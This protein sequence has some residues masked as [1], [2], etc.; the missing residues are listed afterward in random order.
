MRTPVLAFTPPDV[1]FT[2]C[3]DTQNVSFV[4]TN[5]GDGIAYN[6][7]TIV[8]FS[9]F[10]VSNVSAGATYKS[11]AGRFE[12]TNPLAAT[13]ATG[14]SYTLSFDLTYDTWCGGSFPAG[15]LLW[16]KLYEDECGQAFYL[17]V[18][19]SAINAPTSSSSLAVAKT[20][21]PSQIEIGGS[22]TYDVTSTYTGQLN[23]DSPSTPTGLITVVDILPAGLVITAN[24][25]GGDW[26]AGARTLTWTYMPST[27]P[28]T[29][30]F[31]YTV[32][33]PDISQ[34]DT[35]CGTSF[36]NSVVASG[37]DCCGCAIS[38][39]SSQTTVI[40]CAVGVTSDKTSNSP[41]E[42]CYNITYTNTYIFD[43][44]SA[45]LLSDLIFTEHAELKQEYGGNLSVFLNGVDI[46]GPVPIIGTN[47]FSGGS[48]IVPS[49]LIFN[50]QVGLNQK[51]NG[52][53][54]VTQDS[55]DNVNKSI[56]LTPTPTVFVTD[57]T[58]TLA[59]NGLI[60]NF[61]EDTPLAGS[62]L[63]ISYDLT[64]TESTLTACS[65]NTFYSWSSLEMSGGIIIK[66]ATQVSLGSPAMSVSISGLGQIYNTC[67]TKT[68]TLTVTQTSNYNPKDVQVVLSGLNYF[69]VAPG[70]V[71]C[72]GSV[73][74]VACTP[75]IDGSGDYVWTFDDGFASNGA[76]AIFTIK[77]QK[78]CTGGGALNATAY[79]DDHCIDDTN[80]DKLCSV[81]ASETPALLLLADLLIEK[82]PE[83]YYATTN[84]VQWEI[85]L[86]NRGTGTA[87]NVWVDDVL[88]SGLQY[89]HGVNPIVVDNMTGVTISDALDHD[90][91]AINGA[92]VAIME[93]VA[94]ERRRI[95]FI[96]EQ[97]NCTGLTNDVIANWGC[98]NADCQS[99]VTDNSIVQIP[100]PNLINTTTITPVNGLN[101]CENPRGFISVKNAGQIYTYNL[102]VTET[103][104]VGLS[105][106]GG[107]TKWRLNGGGWN[108]P[109]IIWDPS[110][111]TSPLVWTSAEIPELASL[112]PGDII[113][114]EF[115][116]ASDGHFAGGNIT[117]VTQYENPCATVFNTFNST[118]TIT[119]TEPNVDIS[120]E[121]DPD[122]P[123]GCNQ[124]IF[125][126]ITV[127][128]NGEYP[129]EI[130]WVESTLDAAF[131]YTST[132]VTS[133]GAYIADTGD[134]PGGGQ[135]VQ[136]EIT[137]LPAGQSV[138]LR[139]QAQTDQSSDPCSDNT[140][141]TVLAWWG[142]GNP[143]GSS[144][145]KPGVDAPDNALCLS[146][147]SV[148]T[149]RTETRQ[150]I[151]AYLS[152]AMSPSSINSCST[153]SEITVTIENSGPTDSFDN[154]LVL[155]LPEGLTYNAGSSMNSLHIDEAKAIASLGGIGDPSSVAG[156]GGTTILTW[157]N[158]GD[159]ASDLVDVIQAYGGNDTQVLRFTVQSSCY[160]TSN[161]AFNL[162]Y[163]DCCG[164]T[165][166]STT[167]SDQLTSLN[168][169]LSVV[170]TADI[171]NGVCGSDV[172]YTI[173][174]TNNGT[175]NA[176]VVRIVD[177]MGDW[178]SWNG[179]FTEDA[180]GTVTPAR[181]GANPQTWGWEFNNLAPAA[182]ATFTFHATLNSDGD[183]CAGTLRE[184]NVTAAWACGVGGEHTDN[185][186][187]TIGYNCNQTTTIASD[188]PKRLTMPNLIITD[189]APV[190][191]CTT[192]GNFSRTIQVT[193]QN[194][195]D[196]PTN[197]SIFTVQVQDG[198]GWTGT[199]THN[200]V[201][202]SGGSA[203]VTINT[204]TWNPICQTS[205]AGYNF[206]GTVDLNDNVCECLETIGDNTFTDPGNPYA[207]PIPDVTV[208][209]ID[210]ANVSCSSD[211][212]SDNVRV[213]VTNNGCVAANNFQLALTTDGCL[214]FASQTVSV[215]ATSSSWFTFNI[216]GNWADCT[217]DACD[218]IATV[219][220]PTTLCECDGTNNSRT[221]TY[222]ST[223]PDL[224]VTNIDYSNVSC[225]ADAV[226]GFVRVTVQNQGFG[227]ATNFDVKLTT[228]GCLTFNTNQTIAGPIAYGQTTSVDFP[229]AGTWDNPAVCACDFT[230]I[231]DTDND[232]CECDG[233]NNSL[234]TTYFNPF[235]NLR[236]ATV[237]PTFNC[238][239]D[240]ALTGNVAVTVDNNGC[241][242]A[243][244]IPVQLSSTGSYTFTQK[245]VTLAPGNNTT[246]NFAFTPT[247]ANYDVDFTATIDQG[248][249]ICELT[250]SDNTGTSSN[251]TPNIP[252]LSVQNES[253][254][255]S[256]FSDGAIFV[257]GNLIIA[258][259][260]CGQLNDDIPVRFS[261][262]D[263]TACGGNVIS[264]WTT[265]L[266]SVLING[267]STQ[268]FA[269][270]SSKI[271][272]DIVKNS[273]NCQVS[274]LVE[275]DYSNSICEFD[276]TNNTYCADD[277]NI[278]VV[279]LE[280]KGENISINWNS[281]DQFTVSGSVT[282]GN[283]G[284]GSNAVSNIPV[285]FTINNPIG[286]TS[287]SELDLIQWTEVFTSVNISSGGGS[288]LFSITPKTVG[289]DFCSVSPN[290]SVS[291]R[292]EIDYVN[293]ICESDNSNNSIYTSKQIL[294]PYCPNDTSIILDNV[295]CSAVFDDIDLLNYPSWPGAQFG[296]ELQGATV[297]DSLS[298]QASGSRFNSGV[299]VVEYYWECV[300]S[301][302]NCSFEV[303]VIDTA[304][305]AVVCQNITVQLDG[306]GTVSIVPEDI[307]G[308]STDACG[309][310][311]LAL[312][313]TNFDCNEVG[314]N[315]IV[316]TVTDYSLNTSTCEAIVKVE[317]NIAPTAVCK[318]RTIQLDGSGASTIVASNIDGGS[319]DNCTFSLMAGKTSFDC[320]NVGI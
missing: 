214:T 43:G 70:S 287:G 140:D 283:N 177:T 221:E 44:G 18:E 229:I 45:V 125:W 36:T 26:N 209:D 29:L 24:P 51:S 22:I 297:L 250:G 207:P 38:A 319:Y 312:D 277:I 87:Y 261:L 233:S 138:M 302:K 144:A 55:P 47:D 1:N 31:S 318:D 304:P 20:G 315:T 90:G 115:D 11:G 276:G 210:F 119:F 32:D 56:T 132:T 236:V 126:D 185:N 288:Q 190:V 222:T 230:A 73:A 62:T 208:A 311:S 285:R 191:S 247:A 298:G 112:S 59:G 286:C 6:V 33:V 231:V 178:L 275:V 239:A 110:P 116:M 179:S 66:E 102:Q 309:I 93:M 65:Y 215:G 320:T 225:A 41:A 75:V 291:L 83:T 117:C 139:L 274:I 23:C 76:N 136:Y 149:T 282:M 242:D 86:T 189:I 154:D 19:L 256:C 218:F 174:V 203:T 99:D 235:P 265:N 184:N 180:A 71:V 234:T 94:G 243:T 4:I 12:L 290:C 135:L 303:S 109:N 219:D 266:S 5:N 305:P 17:P 142:C 299:T 159:K 260:G 152:V 15:D 137:D 95:T 296:F 197:G 168:P 60:L 153:S 58:P 105:Y 206:T 255:V 244:N 129:I 264:Q 69:V 259:G 310:L 100:A 307:D 124:T 281:G 169:S 172:V 46:T 97:I 269:I 81:T 173:E 252:D 61:S 50:K 52:K 150:P 64:V 270:T 232:V 120:I 82:T 146:A 89:Q 300:E 13:G 42:R 27:T 114:I 3:D 248:G 317:D 241:G 165:Q 205:G 186:P 200:A 306:N 251:Y 301:S 253:L 104:P 175:G 278:D 313:S 194:N 227:S 308:G 101:A 268:S 16:Q 151:M 195:G 199:G 224:R 28:E 39:T 10:T 237:T 34:S 284:C 85:Y 201:I 145:T 84:M 143:D 295:N 80:I 246:L 164:I 91:G 292:V 289:L 130:L 223:L 92:S 30:N 9:A 294:A 167:S 53:H 21:A 271:T 217:D 262:Y 316:L 293:T 182:T 163:Y 161:L 25:D 171:A 134:N 35:Y 188:G 63:V 170:K 216:S 156:A 158:T 48:A 72:G 162:R 103:L 204:G 111:T 88:G 74:P 196:G 98:G 258:N 220:A 226:S 245:N 193:V 77:V 160:Q 157:G 314:A 257:A 141:N 155:T 254:K 272:T 37:T 67:E 40:E 79:F 118:F 213:Q 211:G 183:D 263:N 147:T 228:D 133:G 106:V 187:N 68:I 8:D 122:E 54:Y 267:G 240:G 131:N 249:I 2:Y 198:K 7:W 202:N 279:D 128:N 127:T 96:A 212:I 123:I 107:T 148:S 273:K 57:N 113:E 176:E 280:P 14:D 121:L 238:A 49:D 108:G 78:R 181:I 166:Y 192:D